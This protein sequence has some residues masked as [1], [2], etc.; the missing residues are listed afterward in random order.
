MKNIVF[1]A[2]S[3]LKKSQKHFNLF[4]FV[5]S[6]VFKVFQALILRPCHRI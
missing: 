4:G 3:Q 5:I 6:L 2:N 1:H